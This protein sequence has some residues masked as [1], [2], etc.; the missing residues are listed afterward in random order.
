MRHLRSTGSNGSN[1]SNESI[2]NKV[3]HAE[4]PRRRTKSEEP[5][6]TTTG[7]VTW[8]VPTATSTVYTLLEQAV[9]S[10]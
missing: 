9:V 4:A 10:G 7:N 3:R 5:V 2:V 6:S 8:G 1:G